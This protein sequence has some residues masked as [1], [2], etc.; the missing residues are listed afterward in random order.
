MVVLF[1]RVISQN[2]MIKG[3]YGSKEPVKISYHSAKLGGHRHSGSRDKIS[4]TS[5]E[6]TCARASV[7]IKTATASAFSSLYS[8]ISRLHSYSDKIWDNSDK[9]KILAL[10]EAYLGL[11]QT[12]MMK[13]LANIIN[14]LKPLPIFT[15]KCHRRCFLNTP[16]KGNNKK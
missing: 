4:K 3:S 13:F 12:S 16:L 11:C 5:Q 9:F 10:E 2:H 8:C 1:C 14:G 15:K 6:N 7:L